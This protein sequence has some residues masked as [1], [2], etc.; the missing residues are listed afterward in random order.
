MMEKILPYK[1]R[2][3]G[4][5]KV[6]QCPVEFYGIDF[7]IRTCEVC[8]SCNSEY[9]DE[10]T[11]QEI[12]GEVKKKSLFGVEQKVA[13][14]KSGNSLVMR[15]PQEIVRFMR[16]RYQDTLRVFPVSKNRME[17]EVA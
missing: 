6:S 16:L 9:L 8:T 3:G 1:C 15:L 11:L 5:L 14:T 7:G 12:E 17:I 13:V 2:C 4:I 10:T